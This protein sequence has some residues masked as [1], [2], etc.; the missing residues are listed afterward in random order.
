MSMGQ[1]KRAPLPGDEKK[2]PDQASLDEALD[3]TFPASDPPSVTQGVTGI[4]ADLERKKDK[5]EN[6]EKRPRP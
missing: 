4:P 3:E 1:E 5:V 2:Q 6:P